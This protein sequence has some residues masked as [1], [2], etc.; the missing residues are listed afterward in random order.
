VINMRSRCWHYGSA[1]WLA[2]HDTYPQMIQLHIESPNNAGIIMLYKQS[3]QED[4]PD[5]LLGR[6]IFY[7]EY[8]KTVGDEGDLVLGTW[9]EYLESTVQPLESAESIHVRFLNNE[10]TFK[11]TE[12]NAGQPW[13]KSPLTPK[14]SS[15]TMS[16]F[17]TLEPRA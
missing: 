1:I 7:T 14:N 6:P 12:M 15:N 9:S 3:M 16:P 10:R 5:T 11:F 4:R 8:A 2:N 17:V 13:W